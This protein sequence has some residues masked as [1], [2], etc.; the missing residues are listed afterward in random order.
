MH[1]AFMSRFPTGVTVITTLTD[2][3]TPRGMTC[4]SL[5]SVSLNPPVLSVCIGIWSRTLAA[6]QTHGRLAVNLLGVHGLAAAEIFASAESGQFDSVPWYLADGSGLPRLRDAMGFAVCQVIGTHSVG[7][8]VVVFGEVLSVDLA[9]GLP[10][11][12][13][14]RQFAAWPGNGSPTEATVTSTPSTPTPG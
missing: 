3:G 2:D 1:R 9:M 14:L 11:L 4:S 7:D 8:H 13:G 6:V 10:L 5:T 12:Y